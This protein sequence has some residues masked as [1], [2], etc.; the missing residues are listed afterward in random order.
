MFNGKLVM[1]E[2]ATE[3][4]VVLLDT[5]AW[6]WLTT[7]H[8]RFTSAAC[9]HDVEAAGLSGRLFLSPISMWELAM[10]VAKGKLALS[11]PTLE[12]IQ[13]SKRRSRISDAPMRAETVVDSTVLPGDFHNDPA[14]R[15]IIA[16][17]RSLD[18]HLV[19]GDKS[20]IAYARGGFVKVWKL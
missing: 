18:A 12:W 16:T 8:E 17:A 7:G 15:L 1:T 9:L 5:C 4:P 20:I 10:K 6:I 14:D 11:T 13:Q 3:G 19:T 2:A